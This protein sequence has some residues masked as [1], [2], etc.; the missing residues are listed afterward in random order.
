MK[1][2]SILIAMFAVIAT[3]SAARAEINM[4]FDGKNAGSIRSV[5]FDLNNAEI[6]Q[7]I[8]ATPAPVPDINQNAPLTQNID[9]M[10]ADDREKLNAR[11]NSSIRTAMDYCNRNRLNDLRDRFAVLLVRGEIKE[12]FRFVNNPEKKFV[13]QN[14]GPI[15]TALLAAASGQQ[16]GGNPYCVAWG[17][18]NVCVDKMVCKYTCIVVGATVATWGSVNGI[19][20]II[21]PAAIGTEVCKDVCANVPICADVP[22]CTQWETEI[23]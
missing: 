17:K 12:K 6:N 4:D 15:G 14:N 23:I 5:N 11:L 2:T 8:P 22:Y 13:F 16:K 19:W 21:I 1:K 3:A 20:Q 9:S 18:Q 10:S 7:E